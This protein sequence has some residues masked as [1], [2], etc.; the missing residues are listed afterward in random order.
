MTFALRPYQQEAV[1]AIIS[2][3]RRSIDPIMIEVA[4]GGGKSVIIAEAARILFEMTGKRVLVTAPSSE[5]VTQN[6]AKFIATGHPASIFSASAGQKSLRHPVVFGSPL[7]IKGRISAFK[8]NFAAIFNDECDLITPTIREIMDQMR[9]GNPNLRIVGT[10]ATPYKLG[11]GYIFREWPDGRINGEDV[12]LEPFYSRCVYSIGARDLIGQ[13]YLTKPV[14]GATGASG[15]DT[16]NMHVNKMGKFVQ[17]DVDRAYHGHGRKTA[18]IVAD[19]VAQSRNRRGVLIY[20][21]TV[22]HAEE[23]MASLPPELSAIIT[24]TT[25]DR[26][27]ILKKFE[28]QKIKYVVN[29]GVLTVGVDL[30]HVDVIAVLRKS[31]SVRLLQQ[32]LGRGLRLYDG[33]EDLLYLDYTD[34]IAT[35]TPDGDLF[36]PVVVAKSRSAGSGLLTAKC[37]DCRYENQF[38]CQEQ[39][40]DNPIDE[41]GY[42][43]DVFGH[44]IET[45][46]GPLSAHHGRRCNGLIKRGNEF[47]R[48]GYRWS[49]KKCPECEEPNDIAARYCYVCRAE[50][51]D[52]N[53]RLQGEFRAMKRDPHLPQCDVVLSMATK[54]SIS[55][56]GNETL[57][58]DWVTPYRQF[59]SYFMIKGKGERQRREY[60]AFMDATAGGSNPPRTIGYRKTDQKFFKIL[61][62]N[63]DADEEPKRVAA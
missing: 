54:V 24:G 31:E 5:L 56:A 62:Y 63:L 35:H 47:D 30:P 32:I 55:Q 52:P 22:R 29:V 21:A 11:Q 26:A 46:Y 61:S 50:L 57:R 36:A 53:E 18:A 27:A 41:N 3:L 1:N 14:I 43:V 28:A 45:E 59:S 39:Y 42:C 60:E 34:N 8:N 38:S 58:V 15:Y 48:C 37:P 23:V 16:S 40:K 10:T 19:I 9:I 7:T 33:K 17:A 4:T 25:K 20:A 12:A 51:V 13:G 6:H 44:R 2:N 49:G